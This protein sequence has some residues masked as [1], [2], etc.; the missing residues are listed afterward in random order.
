MGYF[1]QFVVNGRGEIIER[2]INAFRDYYVAGE[3]S[4]ELYRASNKVL[5]FHLHFRS[6]KSDNGLFSIISFFFALFRRQAAATAG[7]FG[8]H[9]LNQHLLAVG[10]KLVF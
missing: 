4:V 2:F 3:R 8:R 1:H 6:V 9:T 5:E 7:I 10:F